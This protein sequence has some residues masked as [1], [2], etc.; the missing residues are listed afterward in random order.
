MFVYFFFVGFGRRNLKVNNFKYLFLNG[1]LT[2][3]HFFC[4]VEVGFEGF[5][6]EGQ[7]NTFKI[8]YLFIFN[9]KHR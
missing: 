2:N 8:Y 9:M 3:I 6:F 4:F 5:N 1:T 7:V